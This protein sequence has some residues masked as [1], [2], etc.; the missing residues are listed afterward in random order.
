[1]KSKSLFFLLLSVFLIVL[2]AVFIRIFF[3]EPEETVSL[4]VIAEDE[5]D[6]AVWGEAYPLQYSSYLKNKEMAP[7]PTGF[8][9]SVNVQKSEKEPEILLNFK[10]MAFSKDY[11]EDRGHPYSLEDLSHSKRVTPATPG[12]CMTCKSSNLRDI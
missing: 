4:A 6:P 10:G 8:G 9:G 3:V 1:L 11:T 7:S 5:Y 12:S 2:I